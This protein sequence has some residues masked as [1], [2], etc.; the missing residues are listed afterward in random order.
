MRKP[1][2]AQRLARSPWARAR[3]LVLAPHPDDETLG[4]GALIA[5]AALHRRLAG[6]VYLTDG[7]AS[8]HHGDPASRGRLSA[9]RR[10]EAV[11]AL[12]RLAARPSPSPIFLNW[13]D[14]EPPRRD[15]LPFEA[16]CR[17]LATLCRRRRVD[18]LAVTAGH[19][20]HCDH[21]AAAELARAVAGRARR[22]L[23]IFEYLVW[24]TEAPVACRALRTPAMP[25]GRRRAALRA[26]RSQLTPFFGEGFRLPA[27]MLR[28]APCDILYLRRGRHGAP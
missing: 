3:W 18:A 20:P 24:A 21:A 19:E 12:C 6:V 11:L 7:A 14:G 27:A 17:Q 13:R 1:H 5:T 9:A 10:R 8:H 28:M 16:A 22:P 2:H 15:D 26:H 23:A 4:A 25:L